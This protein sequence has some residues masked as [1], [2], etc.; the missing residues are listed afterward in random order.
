MT[1]KA[2]IFNNVGVSCFLSG[3]HKSASTLFKGS[4]EVQL[5]VERCKESSSVVPYSTFANENPYVALAQRVLE[6]HLTCIYDKY[7]GISSTDFS[8][9]DMIGNPGQEWGL[10]EVVLV[11]MGD[12]LYKPYLFSRPFFIRKSWDESARFNAVIIIFNLALMEQI[13]DRRSPKALSL[14]KLAMSLLVG[15]PMNDVF[16]AL[17]N[18][19]AVCY[20]ENDDFDSAQLY[21]GM[22]QKAWADKHQ[23][24]EG[25]KQDE[26]TSIE[27]NVMR[28]LPFH[29]ATTSP[30]A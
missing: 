11:E 18:N 16:V 23:F 13:Y 24:V 12:I 1:D 5:A 8:S 3:Y 2:K 7:S 30:A 22:L 20:Y 10:E 27:L 29:G 14:C 4:L 19:I 25:L 17:V 26:C 28:M 15:Q 6:T 9:V 21:M